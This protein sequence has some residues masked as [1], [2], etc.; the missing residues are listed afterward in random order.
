MASVSKGPDFSLDR[1]CFSGSIRIITLHLLLRSETPQDHLLD[2]HFLSS[3]PP[4][5]SYL[6]S[7]PWQS[8]NVKQPDS[9]QG[10][11]LLVLWFAGTSRGR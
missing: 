7:P 6:P 4:R 5:V 8:A 11:E 1:D 10:K 3:L 2:Q 9:L